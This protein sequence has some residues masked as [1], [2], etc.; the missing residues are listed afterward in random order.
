M[1]ILKKKM[2]SKNKFIKYIVLYSKKIKKLYSFFFI[3]KYK[4][5]QNYGY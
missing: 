2:P 3:N 4:N 1:L 5:I